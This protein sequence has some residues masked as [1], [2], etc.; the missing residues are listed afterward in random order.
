MYKD[1][2]SNAGM[3]RDKNDVNN[4]K[5]YFG[6]IKQREF[7]TKY[8]GSPPDEIEVKVKEAIQYLVT[9]IESPIYNAMRFYQKFVYCHPFY[10][11]NGRIARLIVSI[12]LFYKGKVIDWEPFLD[13]SHFYKKLNRCHDRIK[14]PQQYEEYFKYMI[15]FVSK[16][17]E[18]KDKYEK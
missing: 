5:I 9:D 17:V 7:K 18:D 4:G 11:A 2:L 13:K 8:T 3:Y 15:D 14:Q 16:Y 12:Y 1:I 10:D 6:G